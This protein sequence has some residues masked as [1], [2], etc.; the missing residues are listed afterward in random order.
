MGSPVKSVMLGC[1]RSLTDPG[2]DYP[3][4]ARPR[5]RA[6][7]WIALGQPAQKG[8]STGKKEMAMR[9]EPATSLRFGLLFLFTAMNGCLGP[10]GPDEPEELTDTVSTSSPIVRGSVASAYPEA[11]LVNMHVDG[12]P[13]AVCSGAVIAPR[14]VLTAGHCVFGFNG[15]TIHTP[16]GGGQT[17]SSVEGVTYDWQVSSKYVDPNY[18]DV[19]LIFLD[20]PITLKSYP[21]LADVPV[22][23][24]GKIVNVGRIQSGQLSHSALFVSKPLDVSDGRESGFPYSY[25]ATE[26]IESGDSGGP[27][28]LVNTH[29][30]VAVNSG[31]GGGSAVLARVDLLSSWIRDQVDAHGGAGTSSEGGGGMP[32]R[33]PSGG[34]SEGEPN[35]S[36]R[37]ATRLS[38]TLSGTLDGGDQ[39]WFTFSVGVGLQYYD[40]SLTATGDAVLEMWKLSGGVYHPIA[41]GSSTEFEHVSSKRGKYVVAAYSPSGEAQSYTIELRR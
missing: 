4:P 40:V 32:A 20:N 18:H 37:D 25:A 13:R 28:L 10:S 38:G 1:T 14:V 23:S 11:A 5:G 15:W 33:E 31:A 19:G 7:P 30:I 9:L 3:F 17:A 41:S 22:P 6:A 16:F 21:L 2:H 24:E 29:T 36:F 35:D 39:D 26:V 27:D 8:R 12:Q 34:E